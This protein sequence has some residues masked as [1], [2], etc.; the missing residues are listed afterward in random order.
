[1]VMEATKILEQSSAGGL[2]T[3][4]E[5]GLVQL[6]VRAAGDVIGV[7]VVIRRW[8]GSRRDLFEHIHRKCGHR[9]SN[10]RDVDGAS[11]CFYCGNYVP[12]SAVKIVRLKPGQYA[13]PAGYGNQIKWPMV[14][15]DHV[16][17][18][19]GRCRAPYRAAQRKRYGSK[20]HV[21]SQTLECLDFSTTAML[22]RVS[23]NSHQLPFLVG[24]DDGHPFVQVVSRKVATVAAAFE[25]LVP[26]PVAQARLLGFECPRQG[27]WFFV[28]REFWGNGC[29]RACEK[30]AKPWP[31]DWHLDSTDWNENHPYSRAPLRRTRHVAEL[32]IM[33]L[34][35][36]LVKGTVTA[37][38][39]PPLKLESWHCAMQVHHPPAF[40]PDDRSAGGGSLD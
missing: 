39:H 15:G 27:D 18:W 17:M 40:N 24:R 34:P 7:P 2:K 29:I 20:T 9:I 31:A 12:H 10:F 3:V 22:V 14:E 1:M 5:T 32:F 38:D 19:E 11:W 35:F 4:P 21:H 33:H 37:P 30:E 13:C 16:V 26:V 28:P 6:G 8:W 25:Y 36:D 23:V